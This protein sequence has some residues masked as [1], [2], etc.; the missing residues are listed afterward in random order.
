MRDHCGIWIHYGMAG[1]HDSFII[2][3]VIECDCYKL[4]QVKHEVLL[5]VDVG[6]HIGAFSVLAHQKWPSAK[7]ICIEPDE[8]NIECLKKNCAEFVEIRRQALCPNAQAKIWTPVD[9]GNTWSSTLQE[10][11]GC[12][13][14]VLPSF[15]PSQ[16]DGVIDVLKLDC[17]GAEYSVMNAESLKNVRTVLGEF[18]DISLWNEVTSRMIGWDIQVLQRNGTLLNFC[19]TNKCLA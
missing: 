11:P 18:H 2:S 6:A 9:P 17:E 7:I 19:A 10:R 14:S 13:S 8:S 1:R 12:V 4:D 16:L 15:W 5:I 3:E